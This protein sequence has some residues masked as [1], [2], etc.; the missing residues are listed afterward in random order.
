M[1]ESVTEDRDTP[2]SPCI[3]RIHS[4]HKNTTKRINGNN[5]QQPECVQTAKYL[6]CTN[7]RPACSYG[8]RTV[9]IFPPL[10]YLPSFIIHHPA[11][12]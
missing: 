4:S 2:S 10:A 5:V 12:I 8:W 11:A 3:I 7:K 9:T 6:S 1:A